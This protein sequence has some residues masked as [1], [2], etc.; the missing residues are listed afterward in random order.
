M[1]IIQD[2][3]P[4][5]PDGTWVALDIEIADADK[6]KLHRPTTGK[7][8]CLTVCADPEV[9]YVVKYASDLYGVLQSLS[10]CIWVMHNAKFDL[11]HLNRWTGIPPKVRVWDTMLI[12]QIMWSG[13]YQGYSLADCARRYLDIKLD[14]SLQDK[15]RDMDLPNIPEAHLEYACKDSATTLLIAMEQKKRITNQLFKVYHDIDLPVMRVV[16][17]FQGFVVD[18][19]KWAKL[20]ETNAKRAEEIGKELPL[21]PLS[22]SQV[23]A[24]LSKTGFPRIMSTAEDE[25]EKYIKRYPETEAARIAM[26]V[27]ECRKYHKRSSTYGVKW[28]DEYIEYEAGVPMLFGDYHIIGAETGRF[29]C[30]SPN[31]QNVPVRDTKEF[32]EC[33]IARPGNKLIIADYSQ[34]EIGIVAY[35]SSDENLIN[36][37]NTGKDAYIMM[38]KLMYGKDIDKKDPLRARMKTVVLAANYGMSARGLAKKEDITEDEA[39]DALI[40]LRKSFP[41]LVSWMGMQQRKKVKTETASGRITWLNPYSEQCD[42]NALNNPIQ[43]T[44]S[45]MLKKALVEIHRQWKFD[46]P[47]AV[48]ACIHDEIVLD[49]P[50]I[51]AKKVA[52]FVQDVMVKVANDM[53]PGMKFRASACIGNN[54]SEKE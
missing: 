24:Y 4:K 13:Y 9:V 1:Q 6:E 34:Q 43:G 33:F 48:V 18:I 49:V 8:A 7:F 21:N 44:A 27:L 15:W 14:K 12:D 20:A 46:F 32:R 22:P 37:F 23:K 38:A 28:I 47:F 53:L 29:S 52:E 41:G 11:T 51:S 16:M 42:R 10:N 26:T 25:L 36:L 19:K 17:D 31:M 35:I 50:A 40:R 2:L 3:P 45:D 39:E 5:F 30:T 54:W